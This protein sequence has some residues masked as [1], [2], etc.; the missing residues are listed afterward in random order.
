MSTILIIED[1]KPLLEEILDWLNFEGFA[2]FGASNG[3]EGVKM[4]L[5]MRPDLIISDI[6][7]PEKDG[8][9]VLL[10]LRTHQETALTPFFF[11]SALTDRK[12]VRHGMDLGADD[13]IPKPC[14]RHELLSAVHAHLDKAEFQRQQSNFHLNELRE[15]LIHILPHE[16]RTPLVGILG[17]SELLSLDVESLTS[18]EIVNIASSIYMS[19]N[20]LHRL[21]ENFL[22]YTQLNVFG[23]D[24]SYSQD[25][26]AGAKVERPTEIIHP[27][28]EI[29]AL[30]QLRQADLQLATIDNAAINVFE[31]DLKKMVAE[32]VDNACKFSVG[33]TP[34]QVSTFVAAGRYYIQVRDQGCGMSADQIA[35]IGE[36]KQFERASMEQ[37]GIGLGLALVK[38]LAG[39][40]GGELTIT[41]QPK[42]GTTVVISLQTA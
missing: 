37:Q 8:Y 28:A 40:Y 32:L 17:Y 11:L 4:A 34:I 33:G 25:T 26:L 42:Q 22:L 21:T 30:R 2:A 3:A 15:T 38:R 23:R 1:E 20:R 6:T 12:N 13:Y 27:V 18:D 16:L 5:S 19:A 9:H 36:F 10:E 39:L 7:M 31:D 24:L 41:S 29:S 14:D 35:E